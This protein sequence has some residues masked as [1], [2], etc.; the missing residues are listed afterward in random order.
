MAIELEME[1][2]CDSAADILRQRG[3][4]AATWDSG[5]GMIG[6]AIGRGGE[7]MDEPLFFFGTAGPAWAAEVVDE[8]L[9]SLPTDVPSWEGNPSEIARGILVALADHSRTF[10]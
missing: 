1:H 5:G 3:V 4:N 10:E 9:M 2:R 7:P 6:I 8:P